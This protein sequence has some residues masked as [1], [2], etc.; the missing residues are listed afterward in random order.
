M[1]LERGAGYVG[2]MG[3]R[4]TTEYKRERL[5]ALGVDA[6]LIARLSAPIGLA[7]GAVEPREIAVAVLAEVIAVMRGV[8]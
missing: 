6:D 2:S 4:R 3:S 7:I 8:R 5:A 1:A